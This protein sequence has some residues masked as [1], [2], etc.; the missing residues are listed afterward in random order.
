MSLNSTLIDFVKVGEFVHTISD[1]HIY[2][3]H[4]EKLKEQLT[5]TPYPM[6]QIKL[7]PDIKDIDS[8][9]FSD[10]ELVDYKSHPGIK[11]KV[12]V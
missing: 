12:A 7:N 8:F 10:I 4:V 5:R 9:N 6:C 2:L 1:A 11:M 3:D